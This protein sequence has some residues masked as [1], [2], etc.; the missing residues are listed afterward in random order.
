MGPENLGL[1]ASRWRGLCLCVYVCVYVY[2]CA[3]V[4]GG[5]WAP[6][7]FCFSVAACSIMRSKHEG[8]QLT[9]VVVPGGARGNSSAKDQEHVEAGPG[10]PFPYVIFSVVNTHYFT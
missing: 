7:D 3:N 1:P 9:E 4:Y 2:M 5:G 6:L 8:S 10:C